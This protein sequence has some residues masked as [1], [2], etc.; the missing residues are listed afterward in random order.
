[1]TDLT[2]LMDSLQSSVANDSGVLRLAAAFLE[3]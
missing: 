2:G 1:M 3:Y